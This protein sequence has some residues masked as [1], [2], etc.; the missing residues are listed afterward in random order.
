MGTMEQPEYCLLLNVGVVARGS[1]CLSIMR[2][3][4]AIRPSH[5]RLKLVALATISQ[6]A[7]C[8]KYAGETEISQGGYRWWLP[9]LVCFQNPSTHVYPENIR[10][11]RMREDTTY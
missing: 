9:R 1:R 11:S 10:G 5:L 3:L 4:G 7:A 8:N 2:D 6:S